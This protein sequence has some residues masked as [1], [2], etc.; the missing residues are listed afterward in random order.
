METK[1]GYGELVY[2][3]FVIRLKSAIG[4]NSFRIS[5]GICWQVHRGIVKVKLRTRGFNSTWLVLL[6]M[7]PSLINK[8]TNTPAQDNRFAPSFTMKTVEQT[9]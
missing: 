9:Q 2:E 4:Q 8:D 7:W 3:L 6:P 1:M 5:N